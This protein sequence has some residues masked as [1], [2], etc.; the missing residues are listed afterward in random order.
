MKKFAVLCVTAAAVLAGSQAHAA[1]IITQNTEIGAARSAF[2]GT[3]A[4]DWSAGGTPGSASGSVNIAEWISGVGFEGVDLALNGPENVTW[5][6]S[7]AVQRIGFAISTGLGSFVPPQYDNTGAVFNLLTNTGETGTLTLVD[8]G[9]GYA[10]WVEVN[11]ANPFTSLTFT[12]PSGNI[13]DQYWGDVLSAA[14]VPEP[15]TWAMMI[16]GFGMVGGAMRRR[17]S[18]RFSHA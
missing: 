16:L 8:S 15:A 7:A 12:E 17:A 14:P 1:L 4:L 13:A 3:T 5:N 9:S 18:V 11:A 2:G 6:F 10:A